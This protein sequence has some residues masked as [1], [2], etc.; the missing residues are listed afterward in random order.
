MSLPAFHGLTAAVLEE[1]TH[2][3]ALGPGAL[4]DAYLS[5][6]RAAGVNRVARRMGVDRRAIYA[7]LRR[8]RNPTYAFL[9][10]LNRALGLEWTPTANGP[11]ENA[12]VHEIRKQAK[13]KVW[14]KEDA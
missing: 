5:A 13:A 2:A 14:A 11:G 1:L 7:A 10:A 3:R 8:E 4:L 12:D 6:V 9:V